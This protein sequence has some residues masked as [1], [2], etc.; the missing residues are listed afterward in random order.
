MEGR[1]MGT[2]EPSRQTDPQP[3]APLRELQGSWGRRLAFIAAVVFFISSVFPVVAAFVTG[4]GPNQ[5]P[6]PTRAARRFSQSRGRPCGRS[7]VPQ[8]EVDYG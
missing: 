5:T 3:A 2:E 8:Q 7:V 1:L 6:H 4:I